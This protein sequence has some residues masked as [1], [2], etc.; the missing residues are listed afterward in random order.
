MFSLNNTYKHI[1]ATKPTNFKNP[2][3]L[4]GFYCNVVDTRDMGHV[5]QKKADG[6]M[7]LTAGWMCLTAG[8]LCLTAGQ[9]SLTAGWLCPTA[10][11][12]CLTACWI[13]LDPF[14]QTDALNNITGSI[15]SNQI[16]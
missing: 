3:F 15:L 6:W 8:Y 4:P 5:R 9:M 10:G 11:Q 13:C 12:M 14:G 7:C 1:Q 2:F 16:D